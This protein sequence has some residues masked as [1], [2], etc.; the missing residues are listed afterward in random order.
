[1]TVERG[2][3]GLK[4]ICFFLDWTNAV[5]LHGQILLFREEKVKDHSSASIIRSSSDEIIGREN[6]RSAL[7]QR[8]S[9]SE[10]EGSDFL[11]RNLTEKIIL[12]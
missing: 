6:K 5:M 9:L 8:I 2:V 10:N 1:M 4:L 11:G 12:G 7:I 3:S